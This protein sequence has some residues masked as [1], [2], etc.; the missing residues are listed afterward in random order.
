M[1]FRRAAWEKGTA[2]LYMLWRDHVASYQ[3]KEIVFHSEL[4]VLKSKQTVLFITH[5]LAHDT[6]R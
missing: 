5:H 2:F 1:L 4:R 6:L 3:R